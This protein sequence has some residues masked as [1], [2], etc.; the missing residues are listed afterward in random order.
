MRLSARPWTRL[1][2]ICS[3]GPLHKGDLACGKIV[4]GVDHAD[5]VLGYHFGQDRLRV[6]QAL[7]VVRH[8]G[9]NDAP[10]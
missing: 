2:D 7:D 3:G 6:L 1:S 10:L 4:D 8:V 9:D 5:L